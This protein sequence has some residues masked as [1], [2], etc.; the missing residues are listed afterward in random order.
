[1]KARKPVGILKPIPIADEIMPLLQG[2]AESS[3]VGFRLDDGPRPL[4]SRLSYFRQLV[5]GRRV[6]HVGCADHMHNIDRKIELGIWFHDHLTDAASEC[7]GVDIDATAVEYLR[8]NYSRQ[9]VIAHDLASDEC[10][11]SYIVNNKWDYVILGEVLEHVDHPIGF[12]SNIIS[13]L[14]DA[15]GT[16]IVTGPNAFRLQNIRDVFKR[17]EFV[18]SDH[19]VW[20][21]PY[22]LAKIL[23]R[24][25]TTPIWFDWCSSYDIPRSK[26]LKASILKMYPAMRDTIIMAARK[27]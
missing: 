17:Y 18:N 3:R 13:N 22:T 15:L 2:E 14:G 11:P 20:F 10:P 16:L 25:S 27:S 19:R 4:E 5:A 26:Y 8:K 21:T 12:I 6:L 24:A 9:N 7:I 1:M 23:T